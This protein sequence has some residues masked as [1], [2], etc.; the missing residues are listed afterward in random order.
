MEKFSGILTLASR[1]LGHYDRLGAWLFT[2]EKFPIDLG[3]IAGNFCNGRLDQDPRAHCVPSFEQRAS[4]FPQFIRFL[5]PSIELDDH[6][7]PGPFA[8]P[9]DLLFG[10][11]RNPFSAQRVVDRSIILGA[12]KRRGR[13]RG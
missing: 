11:D 6:L 1:V 7:I 9:A 3:V 2:D 12:A 13:T 8:T 10:V 4:C 5:D